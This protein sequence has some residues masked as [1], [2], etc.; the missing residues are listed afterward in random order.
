MG[1][2]SRRTALINDRSFETG[3][4]G[5][6]TVGGTPRQIR[7]LEIGPDFVRIERMNDG[8]QVTLRF[9]N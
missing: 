8:T 4:A 2:A 5:P 3:E 1:S 9:E 7:C 6:V